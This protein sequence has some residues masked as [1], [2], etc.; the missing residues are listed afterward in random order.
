MS[1]N[2]QVNNSESY[3]WIPDEKDPNDSKTSDPAV[4]SLLAAEG[5]HIRVQSD[6][7][8]FDVQPEE[9]PVSVDLRQW[10]SLARDQG[11]INSCTA[12][13]T[14]AMLEYIQRRKY[15]REINGSRLFVY[16]AS[17]NLL[18]WTGDKGANLRTAMKSLVLFGMPP[19]NYWPYDPAKIDDEPPAFCYAFGIRY[20]ATAY[21]RLDPDG[22]DVEEVIKS[23]KRYL[24][25]GL[26][27][28]CGFKIFFSANMQAAENGGK[29][30][31]PNDYDIQNG[32]HA[33]AIFGY[34]DSLIIQ[35]TSSSGA[36]SSTGAFLFQN[37]RGPE[38]GDK[39]FGWLPYDYLRKDL[40]SDWW[41]LIDSSW[42]DLESFQAQ[43][44]RDKS[45]TK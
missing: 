12:H 5:Y 37:S 14:S 35:N 11:K 3:G 39:G 33:V 40:S 15:K 25:D 38:W 22:V 45:T 29:Y 13:A 43:T 26:P 10:A 9:L 21:V 31:V 34:D 36:V 1:E 41:T 20:A 6:E 27:S 23:I 30:P 19:E 42:T 4:Q 7:L 32:A 18:Q 2:A 8:S 16:K 17:R 28:V 44:N 24:V